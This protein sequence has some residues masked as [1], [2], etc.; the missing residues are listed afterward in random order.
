MFY[1]LK[2]WLGE[3]LFSFKH[4]SYTYNQTQHKLSTQT[5]ALPFEDL[6]PRQCDCR[7]EDLSTLEESY[8]NVLGSSDQSVTKQRLYCSIFL[9]LS[10]NSYAHILDFL[11][12]ERKGY[13]IEVDGSKSRLFPQHANFFDPFHISSSLVKIC[14]TWFRIYL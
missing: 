3:R 13:F 4:I 11:Q 1:I 14:V 8:L 9:S 5:L 6:D 7:R 12:K 10:Y 2:R